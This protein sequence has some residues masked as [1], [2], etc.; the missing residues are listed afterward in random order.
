M[1]CNEG[2]NDTF[3]LS[4]DYILQ[5]LRYAYLEVSRL[6]KRN[7]KNLLKKKKLHL[8][9]DLDHTLLHSRMIAKLSSEERHLKNQVDSVERI[10]DGNLFHLE[11][12]GFLVKLRPYVRTFLEEAGAMFE[13]YICTMG[14]R[15]YAVQ[16][17]KLLDP[18]SKYFGSRIIAR[19]DFKQKEKKNLNLVLGQESGVIILDDTDSVWADYSD[20][21]ITVSRYNYF[22]GSKDDDRSY[23]E[24]RTD[25]SE[26]NGALANIL[27]VLKTVHGLYFAHHACKDVRKYLANIR[28]EVLR[29][30]TLLFEDR[31][32][33]SLIW[34]RAEV[35][36]ATCTTI[37]DSSVTHLVSLD[38]EPEHCI[39]ADQENKFLVNPWWINDAY[40]LWSRQPE[41]E[42]YS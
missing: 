15:D 12:M 30:C 26:T 6:K 4:F 29:G 1:L 39:W 9:L 24:E 19:E 11:R 37:L 13:M 5:G 2:V 18:D 33:L 36:G 8:V 40:F 42:Y 10:S 28:N 41:D 16:A 38:P 31:K 35:M 20:N 21:L 25:E 14:S 7:T 32:E 27:R 34:S 3:G 22:K 23:S 17:A